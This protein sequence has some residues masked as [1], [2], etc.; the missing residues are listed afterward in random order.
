MSSSDQTFSPPE[1]RVRSEP[2]AP[3]K[4][5]GPGEFSLAGKATQL[6]SGAG[7]YGR[8][9]AADLAAAGATLVIAS[10]DVAALQKLAAA[11]RA[12]GSAV[13][14]RA[15]DQSS[16]SSILPV[17]AAVRYVTG[18]NLPVDGGYTAH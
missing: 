11:E 2:S 10:R 12:R 5:A 6:T 8:D 9:L 15:L 3:P 18:V 13:H 4:A 17:S 7:S 1:N 14:A 16:E